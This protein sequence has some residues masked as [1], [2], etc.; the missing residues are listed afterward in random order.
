VD[1]LRRPIES[2]R[3]SS[4]YAIFP[5]KHVVKI[6]FESDLDAE[7][8]RRLLKARIVERGGD[9]WSSESICELEGRA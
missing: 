5:D 6:A 3:S 1:L 2:L 7:V 4:D 9:E 8:A